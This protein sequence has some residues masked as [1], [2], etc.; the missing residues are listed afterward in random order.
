MRV[1]ISAPRHRARRPVVVLRETSSRAR[2][3]NSTCVRRLEARGLGPLENG[4]KRPRCR[5]GPRIGGWLVGAAS[6][7]ADTD[8]SASSLSCPGH[9]DLGPDHGQM[10]A[11]HGAPVM[12]SFAEGVA[13]LAGSFGSTVIVSASDPSAGWQ[14][15]WGPGDDSASGVGA[16]TAQHQLRS[17]LPLA[18]SS[19]PPSVTSIHGRCDT[20]DAGRRRHRARRVRAPESSKT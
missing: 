2:V 19:S 12:S 5:N 15:S 1:Q 17:S 14:G 18:R 10:S 9:R 11:R 3:R 16:P 7:A 8:R 6:Q 20:V 4:R 13:G